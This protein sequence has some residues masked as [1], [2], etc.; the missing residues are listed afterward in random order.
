MSS[1]IEIKI[2]DS[3]RDMKRFVMLP[4]KLHKNDPNWIPQ[5][6]SHERAQFDPAKNPAFDYCDS[7]FLLALKDGEVVGRVVAIINRK[8][9]EKLESN[10]G[11]FGWFESIE[12]PAV[13]AALIGAAE[14]WLASMG[15]ERV[16]GPMGFTDNDQTGFLVEGFDELP[17]IAGS[18]NPPWYNDYLEALGYGKE[19]DYVEFRITV[20]DR[21]PEKMERLVGLIRKRTTVRVFNESTPKALAKNWGHQVFD[22]LNESY[23]EL[24]GTTLLGE[25][26]IAY[27][28]KTYLG[29]VDP[30]FIKLA[31]DGD[32]LVGFIIA[33]P[34]LSKAFQK[35]RGRLFPF[36]FLP[37]LR[38]MKNSKVLDFY[39]AGIRPE[40]Q[41]KGI[42]ALMGFEMG[43]SALARGMKFAES[44][45]ELETNHKIQALW[46]LYDKRLHRRARVYTKTL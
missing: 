23:A 30:E 22:V 40:Y 41:G 18:Y 33:M 29:Q 12:D 4:Y 32:R 26:E 46:K 44:N 9:V 20:P 36:G 13:A 7:R 39:L 38:A 8:L 10:T 6:I 45:H 31:A 37:I 14:E 5:L 19:V 25:R 27:Y 2:V 21:I 28:I 15:M 35:A 43:K 11:R 24:Y 3:G 16:S 17:P 34:N 42:D 1:G